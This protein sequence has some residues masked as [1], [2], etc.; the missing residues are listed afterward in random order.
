M[1]AIKVN[2]VTV[3]EKQSG[4]GGRRNGGREIGEKDRERHTV[5]VSTRSTVGRW[6]ERA[7]SKTHLWPS[8]CVSRD[9]HT[10]SSVRGQG[11]EPEMALSPL[12]PEL[13]VLEEAQTPAATPDLGEREREIVQFHLFILTN[14][15]PI[16]K[17]Y[18]R[19]LYPRKSIS[20]H[21]WV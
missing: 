17:W 13:V 9:V 5:F 19:D 21:M 1:C 16:L 7:S 14:L 2:V 10:Q 4:I 15:N 8:S 18:T 20:L 6:N 3:G 11:R 12:S